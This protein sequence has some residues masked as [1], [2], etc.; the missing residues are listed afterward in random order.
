MRTGGQSEVPVTRRSR[1]A[2][3]ALRGTGIAA[4]VLVCNAFVLLRSTVVEGFATGDGVARR[5]PLLKIIEKERESYCSSLALIP[6]LGWWARSQV[7]GVIRGLMG[8]HV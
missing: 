2:Y 7:I 8:F 3:E 5:T 4:D 1:L 6:T